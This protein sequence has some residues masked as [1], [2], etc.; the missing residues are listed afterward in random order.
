MAMGRMEERTWLKEVRAQSIEER[1]SQEPPR[2]MRI[3]EGRL[4][5]SRHLSSE[6]IPC[7]KHHPWLHWSYK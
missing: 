4:A 6:L 7:E 5:L 1:R 2:M 3:W